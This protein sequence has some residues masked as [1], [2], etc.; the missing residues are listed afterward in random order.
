MSVLPK[1]SSYVASRDLA[2][3]DVVSYDHDGVH[4]IAAVLSI[5]PGKI[6]ILNQR[7]REVEVPEVRLHRLPGALPIEVTSTT[8]RIEYLLSIEQQASARS[9]PLEEIWQLVEGDHAEIE[10]QAL[11]K[12]YFGEDSLLDHLALHLTLVRDHI[13]FKRNK[14][15]FSPRSPE[16]V[17]ELKRNLAAQE[18]KQK[19]FEQVSHFCKERL[20]NPELPIPTELQWCI[21][22]LEDT[23]AQAAHVDPSRQKEASNLIGICGQALEMDLRGAAREDHAY[24]ILK[25]IKHFSASTNLSIYRHRPPLEFSAQVEEIAGSIAPVPAFI[26]DEIASGYRHDLTKLHAITIDDASTEDMDDAVSLEETAGGFRLG[27]HISDVASLLPVPSRL[28]EEAFRRATSIYLPERTIHMLPT[29]LAESAFSL[30]IG[31]ARP[32]LSFFLSLNRQFEIQK[33]EIL[34][35]LIKVAEKTSYEKVDA[36]LESGLD[37][38]FLKL[39][40]VGAAH[41]AK[42]LAQGAQPIPKKEVLFSVDQGGEIHL[43]VIDEASSARMLVAELMIM[44]NAHAAAWA[45]SNKLPLVYRTQEPS[46]DEPN[47]EKSDMPPGPALDYLLKTRLKRSVNTPHLSPHF[48]LGL[49]AYCQVTSPIRRYFD[50]INQR[51]IMNFIRHHSPLYTKTEL[52]AWCN[53]LEEPLRRATLVSRESR[54]FWML[55]YFE[56]K[57]NRNTILKGTVIRLDSRFQLVELEDFY[58]SVFAKLKKQAKLGDVV[59]LKISAINPKDDYLRLEQVD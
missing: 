53:Q 21:E 36:H 15:V 39:S 17:T 41:E 33:T 55:R 12:L 7:G 46:E 47:F 48:S 9:L 13:Y 6:S 58:T 30:V 59:S 19:L 27:I 22:L 51:Q 10:T 5:K 35:S 1:G 23:A 8:K 37:S 57:L 45:V 43:R 50:L 29:Q 34:P 16:V 56:T 54:K 25:R 26:A 49:P 32:A 44:V 20:K 4:L 11:T 14:D 40:N 52:E 38:I 24:Q 31:Q 42:R 28:D 2:V 18:A 3:G